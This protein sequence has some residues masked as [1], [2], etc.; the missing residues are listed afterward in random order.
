[1]IPIANPNLDSLTDKDLHSLELQGFIKRY[2]NSW[3]FTPLGI[4]TRN[5]FLHKPSWFER[6]ENWFLRYILRLKITI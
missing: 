4:E 5:Y 6:F 2:S 1:M 3:E